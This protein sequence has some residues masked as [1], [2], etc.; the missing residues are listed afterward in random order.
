M[1]FQ[2]STP[3]WFLTIYSLLFTLL[4]IFSIVLLVNNMISTTFMSGYALFF[5]LF[6]IIFGGYFLA[7]KYELR[8]WAVPLC[9]IVFGFVTISLINS[10]T[11]FITSEGMHFLNFI[12]VIFLWLFIIL[13][14]ILYLHPHVKH[15]PVH[16]KVEE[17][18]T[19][20]VTKAEVIAEVKPEVTAKKTKKKN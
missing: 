20:P 7:K 8:S 9:F 15:V 14:D 12:K 6:N 10:F 1:E 17:V 11:G 18:K 5:V 19:E 4:G 2:K 13:V 16:K 3:K